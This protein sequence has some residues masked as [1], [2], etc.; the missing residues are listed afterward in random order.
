MEARGGAE[1]PSLTARGSGSPL[2]RACGSESQ[3]R[4]GGQGQGRGQEAEDCRGGGEEEED[5][6]VSL[7]TPGRGARGRGCPI[8][9]D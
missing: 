2:C 4:S 7:A 6:G 3:E 9:E 8:R 1:V 5:N